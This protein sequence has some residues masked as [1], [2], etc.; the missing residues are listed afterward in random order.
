MIRIT[1]I[2]RDNDG[3]TVNVKNRNAAIVKI[4]EWERIGG[5]SCPRGPLE[6]EGEDYV[7]WFNVIR[8]ELDQV[9]DQTESE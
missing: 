9:A 3:Y 5:V 6:P 7:P 2:F 8:V 4:Q 1:V